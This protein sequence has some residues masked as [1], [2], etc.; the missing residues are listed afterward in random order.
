V[1]VTVSGSFK[2]SELKGK[3][4]KGYL[5]AFVDVKGRRCKADAVKEYA[6]GSGVGIY[7]AHS[8]GSP[9]SHAETRRGD[10]VTKFRIC[11]YLYPRKITRSNHDAPLKRASVK[12]TITR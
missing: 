5:I 10:V 4:G 1:T 9:F 11:A 2:R 8:V 6:L 12:F 3:S 7:Y